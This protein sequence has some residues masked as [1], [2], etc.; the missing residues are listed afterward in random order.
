MNLKSDPTSARSHRVR[1]RVLGGAVGLLLAGG[2]AVAPA[3]PAF[4]DTASGPYATQALCVS[5]WNAY[6]HDTSYYVTS[7]CQQWYPGSGWYFYY[8]F[9]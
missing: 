6:R 5:V 2:L 7:S 4:A 1:R 9:A 3:V 8:V